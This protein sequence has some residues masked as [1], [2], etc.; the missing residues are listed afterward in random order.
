MKIKKL[1]WSTVKRRLGDLVPYTHNPRIASESFKSKLLKM[2][3]KF[4]LVEIPAVDIDGKILAGHQR[5]AVLLA[6]YGPEY[7]IEVRIPSRALT[8]SE[9]KTYILASNRLHADWDYDLLTQNFDIET[10]LNTGFENDDLSQIFGDA[11]DVVEDDWDQDEEI[12]KIKKP[13]ARLGDIYALGPHRLACIDSLDQ[14]SVKRLVGKARIDMVYCDPIYNLGIKGLYNKGIG[15]KAS[16]GGQTDDS[17]SDTEYRDFLKRSMENALSVAKENCHAYY[18]CDQKYIG[19][20]QSL[21]SELGLDNRRVCLWL[22]GPANPTPGIAFGK[23]YEPCVYATRKKPYIAPIGLNFAE[24]MNKELGPSG[25]K[26]LD[27]IMDS[28][29]IWLAKRI[30]GIEY[31]HPTQKPVTLHERAIKR[32]TKPGDTI[33]DLFGGSGSTLLA[34]DAMKRVCFM[35]DCEPIFIDL[36]IKR[37]EQATG[38]KAK[39]LN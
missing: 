7:E 23:S 13:K 33:L 27:D 11:F 18:Y 31:Q 26:L 1:T 4:G 9:R 35:A 37:Y 12:A 20:V 34:A 15:G 29:D 24:V 32:C 28:I 3:Q 30:A 16:Y 25:N 38:N 22:K 8:E 2:I 6:L 10:M 17:K 21:F 36:I 14:A 5:I 39:K 19:I